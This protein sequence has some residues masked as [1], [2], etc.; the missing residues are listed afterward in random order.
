MKLII[1]KLRE[2]I[3][4]YPGL[5]PESKIQVL[6]FSPNVTEGNG[7]SYAGLSAPVFVEDIVGNIEVTYRENYTLD[8]FRHLGDEISNEEITEFIR[9]FEK[10]VSVQSIRGKAP[11]FGDTPSRERM[12]AQNG[13]L[14]MLQQQDVAVPFAAYRTNIIIQYQEFYE[15]EDDE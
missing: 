13:I 15:S 4:T 10:W 12:W 1:P 8:I 9:D 7:I 3:L 6:P 2:F 14:F 5:D 11:Y